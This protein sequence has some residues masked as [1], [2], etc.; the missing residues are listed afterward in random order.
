MSVVGYSPLLRFAK[1]R[2]SR[3]QKVLLNQWSEFWGE[4]HWHGYNDD[5]WATHR[6]KSLWTLRHR[7]VEFTVTNLQ[8][9]FFTELNIE[10]LDGTNVQTTSGRITSF[11]NFVHEVFSSPATM[12]GYTRD[13]WRM[14]TAAGSALFELTS[15]L[16]RD[17]SS[18]DPFRIL[19]D[20][21]HTLALSVEYERPVLSVGAFGEIRYVTNETTWLEPLHFET[22]NDLLE[23][24]TFSVA[25]QGTNVSIHTSYWLKGEARTGDCR[26]PLFRFVET[27]IEGLT[28]QPIVLR[29]YWSQTWEGI[30]VTDYQQFIFEP[31][32]ES[33]ISP[34]IADELAAQDIAALYLNRSGAARDNTSGVISNAVLVVVGLD[35]TPRRFSD[36]SF[37]APGA[38]R[39]SALGENGWARRS[40]HAGEESVVRK[41]AV[42][43]VAELEALKSFSK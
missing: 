43:P 22:A 32:L 12:M 37:P 18:Q 40:A 29:G 5:I 1:G 39:A 35:G 26:C 8:D 11:S 38:A 36:Q 15:S 42:F 31:R 30:H 9:G 7:N 10:H 17:A 6:L 41:A 13:R 21:F 2:A 14:N 23:D 19:S 25:G 33:G 16:Y 4:A 24:L 20:F 34:Q 27:R 3:H 28:S